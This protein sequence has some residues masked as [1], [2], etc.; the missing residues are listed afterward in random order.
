MLTRQLGGKV[1]PLVE[2]R[3]EIF[4]VSREEQKAV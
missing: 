1:R 3:E 2:K 4:A